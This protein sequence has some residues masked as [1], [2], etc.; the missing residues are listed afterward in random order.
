MRDLHA[1]LIIHSGIPLTYIVYIYMY[2][3]NTFCYPK[4]HIC[5][6]LNSQHVVF[7]FGPIATV[8]TQIIH[9]V[10]T[11]VHECVRNLQDTVLLH[12]S[13]KITFVF[14]SE[15]KLN[16]DTMKV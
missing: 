12:A 8:Y 9:S 5:V 7:S 14:Q 13:N 2:M 11:H 16:G 4:W 1:Y 15:T 3:L 6:P 10:Y